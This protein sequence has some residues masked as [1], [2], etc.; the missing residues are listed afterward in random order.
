MNDG[1]QYYKVKIKLSIAVKGA[2]YWGRRRAVTINLVT[3]PCSFQ[4]QFLKLFCRHSRLKLTLKSYETACVEIG[5]AHRFRAPAAVRFSFYRVTAR[6]A[7][8]ANE[9]SALCLLL[10]GLL[11]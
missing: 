10:D 1:D 8:I 11:N 7:E 6:R 3:F 9:L 4:S 5:A 2:D